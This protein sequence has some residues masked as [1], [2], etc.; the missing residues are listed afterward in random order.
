LPASAEH[1]P[2]L[3]T[4]ARHHLPGEPIPAERVFGVLLDHVFAD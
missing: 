2:L 1:G 4:G 3:L